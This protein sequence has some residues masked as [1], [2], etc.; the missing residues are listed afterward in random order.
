VFPAT[1]ALT[2]THSGDQRFARGDNW[3]GQY[4]RSSYVAA[5]TTSIFKQ[6][7]GMEEISRSGYKEYV[8]GLLAGVATVAIGHPFDTVKVQFLSSFIDPFDCN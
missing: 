7:R 6:V 4:Q 3:Y 5:N 1:A 8:A 2:V